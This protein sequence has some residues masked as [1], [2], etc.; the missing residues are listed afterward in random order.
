METATGHVPQC[1]RN[2]FIRGGKN[3]VGRDIS[4][5]NG[6]RK[7]FLECGWAPWILSNSF[8][9]CCSSFG[10]KCGGL[11]VRC[12]SVATSTHTV[13]FM[14]KHRGK[15]N[16]SFRVY[17]ETQRLK[18]VAIISQ[19]YELVTEHTAEFWIAPNLFIRVLVFGSQAKALYSRIERTHTAC[20]FFRGL[21]RLHAICDSVSKRKTYVPDW[22]LSA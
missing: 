2:C 22:G 17:H 20:E 5:F 19:L 6:F 21:E 7:G 3:S 13:C 14:I 11:K 18:L 12:R 9:F 8:F 4:V 15:V 16:R 10:C 1:S